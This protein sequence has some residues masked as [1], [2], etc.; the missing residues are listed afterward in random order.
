[1]SVQQLSLLVLAAGVGSRYGGD[2]Q[3]DSMGPDGAWLMEYALFD[4]LQAGFSRAVL[5]IRE[6]LRPRVETYL[7]PRWRS[8]LSINFILQSQPQATRKKPWGTAHATLCA[9][10]ALHDP[11]VLIN[12]DDFYG[13]EAFVASAAFLRQCDPS[14]S[15]WAMVGYKLGETL[16]EVG[17]VS[18]GVCQVSKSTV[19]RKIVEE[20]DIRRSD[21]LTHSR[22][23]L[24][25]LVSMNC[26]AFT[27]T[28]FPLLQ[29]SWSNFYATHKHDPKAECYLP[30]VINEALQ[31][32]SATVE[33]LPEG[34]QWIGVT[35]PIE[36]DF[37]RKRLQQLQQLGTYPSEIRASSL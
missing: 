33:V 37:V 17:S 3:A 5:V 28:L 13:R 27:P 1:M 9:A 29:Q 32:G 34:R 8:R 6:E 14:A 19:L 4:A 26:W 23:S 24:D 7:L 30:S 15:R 22:F 25:S 11:F 21:L 36:R 2:K 18:R 31:A 20:T 10:A 35:Y 16:S 12:A